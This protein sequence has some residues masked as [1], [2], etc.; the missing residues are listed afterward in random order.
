MLLGVMAAFVAMGVLDL[1]V[2]KRVLD[3][4]RASRL[5]LLAIGAAGVAV[6]IVVATLGHW[7]ALFLH[8]GFQAMFFALWWSTV[9][10]PSCHRLMGPARIR[11]QH[12]IFCGT[13]LVGAR[14]QPSVPAQPLPPA[15]P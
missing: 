10:C 4:G 5:G 13:L 3:P 7:L 12:C 6:A 9:F 11:K 2:R 14:E 8:G 15:N 1:L